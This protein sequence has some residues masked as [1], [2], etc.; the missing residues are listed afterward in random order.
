ML[1]ALQ[2]Q[3][4]AGHV[5]TNAA[6]DLDDRLDE[7]AR[8]VAEGETGKAARKVNEVRRKLADFRKDGEITTEGYNAIMPSLD[9]L[10]EDLSSNDR[11]DN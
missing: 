10:A 4:Q 5:H 9:L 2:S 3:V 7:I 1:A 11:N 6:A 8:Y